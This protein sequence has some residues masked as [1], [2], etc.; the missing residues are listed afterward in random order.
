MMAV[1]H[2]SEALRKANERSLHHVGAKTAQ[3]GGVRAGYIWHRPTPG[4]ELA[5]LDHL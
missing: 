1:R 2:L 5:K 4:L 3:T